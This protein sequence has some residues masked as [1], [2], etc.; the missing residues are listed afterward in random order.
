MVFLLALLWSPTFL[1]VRIGLDVMSPITLTLLRCFIGG[2]IL[3]VIMCLFN[4]GRILTLFRE[5]KRLAIGGLLLNAF[6]FYFCAYGEQFV[7]SSTAG[8]VEATTPIFVLILSLLFIRS[9]AKKIHLN[10][11]IGLALGFAGVLIIFLP[12]FAFKQNI[13]LLALV[14]MAISFA[15]GFIFG[16]RKLK[17]LPAVEAVGLQMLFGA[18]IILPFW[19]FMPSRPL[20]AFAAKTWLVL[21][22][23]SVFGTCGGWVLYFHIVRK[24]SA[25]YVSLAT[26]ICP[27][28]TVGWGYLILSEPIT[29]Y[30]I[31]GGSLTC[32]SILF[33]G[34]L[35]QK[36]QDQA[37]GDGVFAVKKDS[38]GKEM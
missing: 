31:I 18:L 7:D 30:K 13:G 32:V 27:V 6:P 2:S 12:D 17:H 19:Y 14:G 38:Q 28:M 15:G 23:L 29:W 25:A 21:S 34:G 4:R 11:I 33:V 8:I 22:V 37:A 36:K 20:S 10:S 5:W 24:T 1:M 26:L 16:E 35:F 9:Y 3:F